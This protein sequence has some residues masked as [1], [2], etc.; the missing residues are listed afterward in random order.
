MATLPKGFLN[1]I[2]S[3]KYLL[4]DVWTIDKLVAE[5]RLP[6]L[7]RHRPKRRIL[8]FDLEDLNKL[9]DNI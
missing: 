2:E 3:A 8:R 6:C 1:R 7:D 5:G 4:V 9:K